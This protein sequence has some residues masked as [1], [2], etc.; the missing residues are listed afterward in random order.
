VQIQTYLIEGLIR[1]ENLLDDWWDVDARA[2]NI[3]GQ[4]SGM[5]IGIGDVVSVIIS[6]IDLARRELDLSVTEVRGRKGSHKELTVSE[7]ERA[8]Q[9]EAEPREPRK[10]TSKPKPHRKEPH[11]KQGKKGAKRGGHPVRG[12]GPRQKRHTPGRR[13]R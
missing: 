11:P 1:Y 13:R 6:R 3:R 7:E 2:G 8:G 5:R 12:G 10:P 9:Q 4:R